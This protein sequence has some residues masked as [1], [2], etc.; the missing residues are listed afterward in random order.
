MQDFQPPPQVL[1]RHPETYSDWV[2]ACKGGE[3]AASNFSVAAPFT[4]WIA[5][6]CIALRVEGKLEWN[7][8]KMQFTN[9]KAANQYLKPTFRKGWSFT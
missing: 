6:A 2:R 4:E 7:A 1:V 3:P 9:S 8:A 5:M